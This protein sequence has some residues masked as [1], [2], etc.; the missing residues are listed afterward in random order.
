MGMATDRES[1]LDTELRAAARHFCPAC[2]AWEP[3][4]RHVKLYTDGSGA[5]ICR[6]GQHLAVKLSTPPQWGPPK[7]MKP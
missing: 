2:M 4:T 3:G 5:L 6:C 7:D 1:D